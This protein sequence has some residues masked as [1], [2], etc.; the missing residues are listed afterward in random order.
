MSH[1]LPFDIATDVN[2]SVLF[3]EETY[4]RGPAKKGAPSAG[5]EEH[6]APSAGLGEHEA[7]SAGHEEHGALSAGLEENGAPSAGL[8]VNGAPGSGLEVH[9]AP[10][11]LA[12]SRKGERR[13]TRNVTVW[14]TM[15]E[16]K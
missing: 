2:T 10:M 6:G 1:F 16:Y 3:L 5:L 15:G 11:T 13:S 14:I 9:G 7:P 8:E 4:T 12:D